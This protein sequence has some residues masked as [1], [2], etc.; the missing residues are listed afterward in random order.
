MKISSISKESRRVTEFLTWY[1]VK[2]KGGFA[3][4][5]TNYHNINK[6]MKEYYELRKK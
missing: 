6:K 4:T 1:R 5:G 2:I 3:I